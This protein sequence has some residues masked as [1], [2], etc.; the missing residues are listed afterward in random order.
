MPVVEP[1]VGDVEVGI[2]TVYGL[3]AEHSLTVFRSCSR[4]LDEVGTYSRK[5]DASGQP[6]DAIQDKD[7]FH[8]LDSTRYVLASIR[9]RK[10]RVKVVRLG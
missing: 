7:T 2:Q 1:L 5:M 8:L 6:T 3:M 10:T 9:Q 4:W